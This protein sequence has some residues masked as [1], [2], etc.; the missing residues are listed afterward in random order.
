MSGKPKRVYW[1]TSILISWISSEKRPNNEML[2]V[3]S[4]LSEVSAGRIRIVTSV[5]TEIEVFKSLRDPVKRE[6]FQSVLRNPTHCLW[7]NVDPGVAQRATII[8]DLSEKDGRVIATPDAIHI[9]S[10]EMTKCDEIHSFDDRHMLRINGLYQISAR[11]IKPPV[12]PLF[13]PLLA[14]PLLISAAKKIEN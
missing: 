7:V 4:V 1:D 10:A 9:A 5:I 6:I 14:I 12:P 8:R 11:I 2:G 3:E 13:A